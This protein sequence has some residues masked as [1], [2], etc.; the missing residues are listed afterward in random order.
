M[1]PLAMFHMAVIKRLENKV[2]IIWLDLKWWS[3][4]LASS[5]PALLP[6]VLQRRASHSSHTQM[7]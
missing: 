4:S 2:L 5:S 3:V 6:A 1:A 7:R